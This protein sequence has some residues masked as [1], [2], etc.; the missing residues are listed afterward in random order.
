VVVSGRDVTSRGNYWPASTIKL[1]PAIAVVKWAMEKRIGLGQ[2]IRISE[3][4]GVF[5]DTLRSI[6]RDT[7]VWSSNKG[8]DR[9]VRI[10]GMDYMNTLA[11]SLGLK[12]TWVSQA[13]VGGTLKRSPTLYYKNASGWHTIPSR[14]SK[15]KSL[16]P[17]QGNCT[18]LGDLQKLLLIAYTYPTLRKYMLQSKCLFLSE[19]RQKFGVTTR[20]YSKPGFTWKGHM[21]GNGLIIT[22]K[23]DRYIMTVLV[24][25]NGE[26]SYTKIRKR[27][28]ILAG[29]VLRKIKN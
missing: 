1:L 21:I 16:C 19:V 3:P 15:L 24:P 28:R 18:S 11:K 6:L 4:K 12:H 26:K 8:Y 13:F 10:A 27:L 5:K 7:L 20:I 17:R 2:E 29:K 23:G 22:P 25:S 9:L 14:Y